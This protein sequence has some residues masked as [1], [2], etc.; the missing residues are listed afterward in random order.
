M[1]VVVYG[2]GSLGSLFGGLLARTHEVT[3][4]GRDPHVAAVRN[5]G[6]QVVGIETFETAPR[7]TTGG[8][9]LEGDL[10]LVT[11]KAYDTPT[12]ARELATGEFDAV[13]SVQNGMGN[14]EIL[15]ECLPCPVLAGTTSHGAIHRGPGVVEW[16]GRGDVTVGPWGG[17]G[18]D[19][20]ERAGA[21]F[22][23][24]GVETTVGTEVRTR[25]W[26]KLAVNAAINPATA[27]ARMQNGEVFAGPTAEC[28][29][30]AARETARV[31]RA[32]GI[33]LTDQRAIEC[34]RTV[35]RETSGNRSSMYQDVL[36]GKRTEIDA[37][38]GFVAD[39]ADR[40]G[41][42]APVN[43][44]FQALIRGWE[45]AEGVR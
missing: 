32:S 29:R 23:E 28:A 30:T 19:V 11:V 35:A 17:A 39:R 6:L 37:V 14:E 18:T 9:G 10:A 22:R 42:D 8:T 2:A 5:S 12:A 43:R 33:E 25:L 36:A 16:T 3:L 24:A 34:A 21:A 31:A 4:V 41:L 15:A 13:L 1:E 20:A 44:V 27:L 26:E 7:A 38:S 40:E 45:A